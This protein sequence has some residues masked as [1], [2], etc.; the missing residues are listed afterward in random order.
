MIK[1]THYVLLKKE[2]HLFDSKLYILKAFLAV[3][4]AYS[5]A[6]QFDFVKKDMISVLF[7]LLLTLEPVTI[8]GIRSG[9]KQ[10]YATLLGALCTAFIISILGI[11]VWTIALSICATLFVCLKINWR[12]VSPV[13]IFTSIYM[14]QYIQMTADGIPSIALTFQLR[15]LALGIGVFI[16]IFYNFIFSLFSYKSMERKRI[17]FIFNSL[18]IHLKRLQEGVIS[19]SIQTIIQEKNNLPQTFIGIDWLYSLINDK[20]KEAIFIKKLPIKNNYLTLVKLKQTLESIRTITHLIYDSTNLLSNINLSPTEID[21]FEL[22]STHLIKSLVG[23]SKYFEEPNSNLILFTEEYSST[24]S[25]SDAPLRYRL[26]SNLTQIN[27][28][29]RIMAQICK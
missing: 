26:W 17:A 4:T 27:D 5:I 24:E 1:W 7:G 9:L 29:L 22:N 21:T 3:L 12:E 10:I 18:A 15:I 2:A 8:T 16:A 28:V 13:A 19:N 20:E 6:I 25:N 11:N 14:T 23:F